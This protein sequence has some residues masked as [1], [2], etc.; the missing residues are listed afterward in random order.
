MGK[1]TARTFATLIPALGLGLLGCQPKVIEVGVVMPLSGEYQSYGQANYRGVQLAFDEIMSNGYSIEI[2][3]TV[4][5]SGSDP[6]RA[7]ELLDALYAGGAFVALGG[8]VSD[9]AKEMVAVAE[10]YN[11]VLLSPSATSPDLTRLSRNFY[12]IAA[13]DLT[14]GNKMADFAYRTLEVRKVAVIAEGQTFARS[15]QQAFASAF[16]T[17]GGEV[18]E[19]IEL[20]PHTTDL[21]G[22]IDRILTLEP[23]AVYLAAYEAG[24]TAMILELRRLDFKGKILTTHAF[25]S[26]AAIAQAGEAAKGVILTKSL[27]E[28]DSEHVHVQKFVTA[29]R[30]R[31]DED[32]DLF[33]AEGYDAMKVL[34]TALEKRH[35]LPSEMIRGLR[36]EIKEFPGV[37]GNIQFDENGDVRKF[38][39]VYIIGEGLLLYDYSKRIEEDRKKLREQQKE[40]QRRLDEL[41]NSAAQIGNRS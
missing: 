12:R 3:L 6:A 23:Q 40:L 28:T 20:P 38:P 17:L 26:P 9:E 21:S 4:E 11:R 30:E 16:E 34:A 29:Y 1:R 25:S 32:P 2:A 36:D 14:E 7:K 37:T 41:R 35:A 22:L 13:S 31:Y 39:R 27:F 18:V 10:K 8:S 33:A 15:I 24:V 5:D 19:L